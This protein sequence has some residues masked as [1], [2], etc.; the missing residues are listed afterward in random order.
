MPNQARRAL[1][2]GG[3]CFWGY[4]GVF[5]RHP[6][7]VLPCRYVLE[8]LDMRTLQSIFT[9]QMH[10]QRQITTHPPSKSTRL[11]RAQGK[12]ITRYAKKTHRQ[13]KVIQAQILQIIDKS[14][15]RFTRSLDKRLCTHMKKT[16][17]ESNLEQV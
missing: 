10:E 4:G 7:E 5:T 14:T 11:A 6:H 16:C 8:V 3:K 1:F 13:R 2:P 15:A 9:L 17:K 12:Q